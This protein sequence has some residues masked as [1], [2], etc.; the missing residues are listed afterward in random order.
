MGTAKL[1]RR[2]GTGASIVCVA[3]ATGCTSASPPAPAATPGAV[4]TPSTTPATPPSAS[5]G[6][7]GP[8]F[9]P[10]NFGTVI[11][12][13]YYPLKPGSIWIYRGVREGATQ[14]DVVTA[15]A[16]TKVVDGVT[17]IVVTDVAT[18][19]AT[20][21]ERTEDWFA[22]DRQGNVWYL[23]EATAAYSNGKV[24][25]EG[26]WTAGVDG[27]VPGIIMPAH[28]RPTDS[29][30]QEYYAGHAEDAFWV[31]Q[32]G[33]SVRVP[34]GGYTGVIRT[35]EF[36]RLEPDVIDTK[37]YAPGIGIIREASATGPKET[38]DLTSFT[39]G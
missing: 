28:P 1:I 26:S 37:Y 17:A 33:Q 22:Q 27:A 9:E 25:T 32:E 10:G 20:L 7:T 19:G 38:A 23:G 5:A 13:P 8:T 29:F 24:D 11:D 2:G 21:L 18:H 4:S 14:E 34:A 3:L 39:S 30:R 31:V 6:G 12:N 35:L 36:T 16:R 15:T